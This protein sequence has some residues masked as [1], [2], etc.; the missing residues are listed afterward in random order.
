MHALVDNELRPG[1]EASRSD[2]ERAAAQTRLIQARQ[3]VTLGHSLLT[4]NTFVPVNF[5]FYW[6][7][8]EPTYDLAKARQLVQRWLTTAGRR[9]AGSRA[10]SGQVIR[11]APQAVHRGSMV[12][13]PWGRSPAGFTA[14]SPWG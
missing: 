1:A 10:A 3:A 5:D 11:H 4:G 6:R 14:D 2:A 9:G 7:A 8:P 12:I 13:V